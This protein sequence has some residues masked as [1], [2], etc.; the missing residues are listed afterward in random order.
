MFDLAKMKCSYCREEVKDKF[1]W[2]AQWHEGIIC[3]DCLTRLWKYGIL[4]KEIATVLDSI[5]KG[6]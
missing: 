6:K 4:I 1:Y 5:K 2:K 3:D